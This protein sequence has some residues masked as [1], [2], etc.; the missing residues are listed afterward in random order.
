MFYVIPNSMKY[1]KDLLERASAYEYS[2]LVWTPCWMFSSSRCISV[3]N[4]VVFPVDTAPYALLC[5]MRTNCSCSF[6]WFIDVRSVTVCK[7]WDTNTLAV[8]PCAHICFVSCDFIT[9]QTPFSFVFWQT[10]ALI[11]ICSVYTLIWSCY[12]LCHSL[13]FYSVRPHSWSFD[14]YAL[15]VERCTR[16]T[17]VMKMG[18]KIWLGNFFYLTSRQVQPFQISYLLDM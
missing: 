15:V 3:P 14:V 7:L 1:R 10:L 11:F 18:Q 13:I 17:V 16:M 5:L 12:W 6:L 2:R 8:L 9:F 4:W